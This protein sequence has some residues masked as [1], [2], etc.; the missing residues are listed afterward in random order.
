MFGCTSIH[1]YLLYFTHGI[2]GLHL[3]LYD[4]LFLNFLMKHINKLCYIG[5]ENE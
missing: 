2:S 1:L 5:N 4:T 3:N